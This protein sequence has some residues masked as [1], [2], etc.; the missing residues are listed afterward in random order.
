[1]E[2]AILD[3]AADVRYARERLED[4]FQAAKAAGIE[5]FMFCMMARHFESITDAALSHE[6]IGLHE[7]R[8]DLKR[9]IAAA[10]QSAC[11]P[12]SA[13]AMT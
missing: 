1:M 3:R 12:R 9:Q 10:T 5:T 2:R 4:E 6:L 11:N 13:G 8:A 7:M